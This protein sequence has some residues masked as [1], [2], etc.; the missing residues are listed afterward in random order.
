MKKKLMVLLLVLCLIIPASTV[1][2]DTTIQSSYNVDLTKYSVSTGNFVGTEYIDIVAP[3]S[4]MVKPFNHKVGD[5]VEAGEVLFEMVESEVKAP[6]DGTVTAIFAD[7]GESAASANSV[8]GRIASLAPAENIRVNCTYNGAYNNDDNKMVHVGEHVYLKQN[9]NV[10]NNSEGIIVNSNDKGFVVQVT[11]KA[12]K[13]K[14]NI[15]VYRDSQMSREKCIGSGTSVPRPDDVL[16][17]ITKMVSEIPQEDK[18][19]KQNPLIITSLRTDNA[20]PG[21]AGVVTEVLAPVGSKVKKG[22]T[23]LK[24]SGQDADENAKAKLTSS[25]SGTITQLAVNPGQQ[26]NKGQLM[27]R[28]YSKDNLEIV[29]EIDEVDLVNIKVGD[30]LPVTLDAYP[31]EIFFGT[32]TSISSVGVKKQNASYYDVHLKIENHYAIN[33]SGT[34]NTATA[35]TAK[36]EY[37]IGQTASVYTFSSNFATLQEQSAKDTTSAAK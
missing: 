27:A 37:K 30:V 22:D 9:N 1:F 23:I 7:K 14:Q 18:S 19:N 17:V 24:V 28:V 10:N 21:T 15:T 32:I 16:P 29:A 6:E 20:I 25:I 35:S 3:W 13:L 5:N 12:V 31:N 2:S 34:E 8:Y 36:V 33:S 11:G 4:G 26:V